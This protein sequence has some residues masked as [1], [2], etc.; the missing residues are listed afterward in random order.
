MKQYVKETD[1]EEFISRLQEEEKSPNT[2][3]KYRRDTMA[4]VCFCTCQKRPL[5]KNLTMAYKEELKKKYK[6]ASANSM[7]T[8]MNRF[9]TFLGRSDCR[10]QTLKVQRRIFCEEREELTKEEYKRLLRTA[11]RQGDTR[12]YLLLQTICSTGIRVSELRHITVEAVRRGRAVVEC[13]GKQ[14]IIPIPAPLQER[15]NAYVKKTGVTQ[16]AVFRSLRG[17]PMERTLVWKCMKRLCASSG[18]AAGKVFPHNLRHLFARTFY[19][20]QHDIARLA[21]LLGHSS[22]ETTRIYLLTTSR[23]CFRQVAQLGLVT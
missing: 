2:L 17:S 9:L 21:D 14:R 10:V 11:K 15:L 12:L 18:V 20:A 16:G 7:L 23:E 8:A 4:F 5:D 19:K 1:V 6:A 3:E 22:I 13:K